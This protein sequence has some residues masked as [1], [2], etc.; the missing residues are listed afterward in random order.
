MAY[1]VQ[2]KVQEISLRISEIAHLP[3]EWYSDG[4]AQPQEHNE[5]LVAGTSSLRSC[6]N[7]ELRLVT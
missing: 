6:L 7:S 1:H 5:L 2:A 3:H 4:A